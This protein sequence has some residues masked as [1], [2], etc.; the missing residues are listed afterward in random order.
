MVSAKITRVLV[1]IIE[2]IDFTDRLF[3]RRFQVVGGQTP[4]LVVVLDP[5]A[6]RQLLGELLAQLGG[7]PPGPMWRACARSPNC[8]RTPW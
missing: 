3:T 6:R 2:E 4:P 1:D 7:P 5:A 8:C